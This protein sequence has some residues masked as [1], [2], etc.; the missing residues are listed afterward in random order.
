VIKFALTYLPRLVFIFIAAVLALQLKNL[1]IAGLILAVL[2]LM[3]WFAGMGKIQ[4]YLGAVSHLP[5]NL[6][7]YIVIINI[8]KNKD[9]RSETL[10]LVRSR[11]GTGDL[12]AAQGIKELNKI[13]ACASIRSN[14]IVYFILNALLLWDYQ[15]AFSYEK[16][17][18]KYA[19]LA[20]QWFLALGELESLLCFSNLPNI[21]DNASLPFVAGGKNIEAKGLGHP[22]IPGDV[23]V[24]NDVACSN[25]IFIISGSNMS[26]KTTFLRTIGVNLVLARAGSFVCAQKMTFSL[27]DIITSMRIEDNLNEGISTFYAEL[28]RIKLILEMA[29]EKPNMIF[30]IDE[31][32]RGTNS[33]DRLSGA[34]TVLAKLDELDTLGMITTHDLDLCDLAMHHNRIKNFSFSESYENNELRFDYKIRPGKSQT[35][36]AK[37]LMEMVG[38]LS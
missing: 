33:V 6:T 29:E 21:C 36:N 5:Y 32:F 25:S 10:N 31:I 22:L 20:E 30:L 12:S 17:K 15:C 4:S 1:F 8:L 9:Y 27:M 26:G 3:I 18:M 38:I 2:Q 34:K 13:A 37:F 16:W 23:R 24:N 14:G 19:P 28:K 7:P 11:L 35:T